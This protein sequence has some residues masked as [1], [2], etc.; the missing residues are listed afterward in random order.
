MIEPFVDVTLSNQHKGLR[1]S[2]GEFPL[3]PSLERTQCFPELGHT[4]LKWIEVW[5]VRRDRQTTEFAKLSGAW[6]LWGVGRHLR[7]AISFSSRREGGTAPQA[8]GRVAR[9]A[10][11]ATRREAPQDPDRLPGSLQ[12]RLR[13]GTQVPGQRV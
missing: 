2:V 10:G 9:G 6:A 5:G 4:A 11:P 8:V 1:Q 13:P 12:H 7:A 3:G